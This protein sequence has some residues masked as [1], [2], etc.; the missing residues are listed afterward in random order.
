LNEF[1]SLTELG[2]GCI[3]VRHAEIICI[4]P[5]SYCFSK[6]ELSTGSTKIVEEPPLGI[7]NKIKATVELEKETSNSEN[8][9]HRKV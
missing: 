3:L 9:T 1:I 8:N 6:I 2:I 4:E 5:T 7:I